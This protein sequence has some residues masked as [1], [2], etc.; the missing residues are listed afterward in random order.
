MESIVKDCISNINGVCRICNQKISSEDVV[1]SSVT[2]SHQQSIINHYLDCIDKFKSLLLNINSNHVDHC[3][4]DNNTTRKRKKIENEAN[5]S[6]TIASSTNHYFKDSLF[7]ISMISILHREDHNQSV[8]NLLMT[9]KDAMKWKDT[10]VFPRLPSIDMIALYKN[11]GRINQ[12]P[13]RYNRVYI[14]NVRDRDYFK[15]NPDGLI[16]HH[17]QGIDYRIDEPIPAGFIP[18]HFTKIQVSGRIEVGSIPPFTTHLALLLDN[19]QDIYKELFPDTLEVLEITNVEIGKH[20]NIDDLL[21]HN[22]KI[23]TISSDLVLPYLFKLNK[24]YCLIISEVEKETGDDDDDEDDDNQHVHI[25]IHIG[26]IPDTIEHLYLGDCIIEPGYT[27]PSGVKY[28]KINLTKNSSQCIPPSVENLYINCDRLTPILAGSIP[29]S[30]KTLLLEGLPQLY[31]KTIPHSVTTLTLADLESVPASYVFPDSIT[32]LYI[33]GIKCQFDGTL[34]PNSIKY[35]AVHGDY[36]F[37]LKSCIPPSTKYFDYQVNSTSEVKFNAN[38]I[39]DGVTHIRIGTRFDKALVPGFI[40]DSCEY[41]DF[42]FCYDRV[43]LWGRV[44]KH[45][46]TVCC[47]PVCLKI[48]ENIPQSIKQRVSNEGHDGEYWGTLYLEFWDLQNWY[49]EI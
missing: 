30:V 14:D 49:L 36:N 13:R 38:D 5:I 1:D 42:A 39:P 33:S 3:Q 29:S 34:L 20:S 10:V 31:L 32:A 48:S 28:L 27:L 16:N 22:L 18:D 8:M 41:L 21:P 26:S 46:K 24:L 12:L 37:P 44:P 11:N 40:P 47:N 35:F 6:T 7:K 43:P 17:C 23:L 4:Q 2:S 25:D 15:E 45:L 19:P 9:C